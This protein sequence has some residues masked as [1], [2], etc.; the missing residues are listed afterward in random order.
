MVSS[1]CYWQHDLGRQSGLLKR[2]LKV[3]PQERD[4]KLLHGRAMK[5]IIILTERTP[6]QT[7]FINRLVECIE[8]CA[9]LSF[10]G[11]FLGGRR[12]FFMKTK[13]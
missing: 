9:N 6:V 11:V 8:E 12:T 1:L 7:Y 3:N 5:K 4:A 13:K 2:S 10:E